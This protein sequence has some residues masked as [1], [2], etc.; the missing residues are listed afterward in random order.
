[1]LCDRKAILFF[2]LPLLFVGTT[3]IKCPSNML[4]TLTKLLIMGIWEWDYTCKS[5]F[6]LYQCKP[7]PAVGTFRGRCPFLI[8][9]FPRLICSQNETG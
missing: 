6:I 5:N 3:C 2:S 8:L 9:I 4:L 7:E 1:M